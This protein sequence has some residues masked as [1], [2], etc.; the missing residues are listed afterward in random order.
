MINFKSFGFLELIC[1]GG[2]AATASPCSFGVSSF[3]TTLMQSSEEI[4]VGSS[5][6]PRF[7]K[8]KKVIIVHG[9]PSKEEYAI[10][11]PPNKS[12]WIPWLKENLEKEKIKVE[13]PLMPECWNPIYDN[14]KKEFEKIG[15]DENSILVGHSAGGGFLVRWL[16]E[17]GK[18]IKK[19][20]LVAPAISN[21]KED[22]WEN[23][24][25]YNFKI[26]K[27]ILKNVGEILIYVSDDDDNSILESVK[28]FSK[29]LGVVPKQFHGY[30]HF[31][32]GD[33]G[34]EKFPELLEEILK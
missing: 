25:L 4:F 26:N 27:E 14:W 8:M 17:T 23:Q 34:T 11:N 1:A 13:I 3:S 15:V 9:S 32:K 31:C 6:T 30:G 33:M 2:T 19:L 10:A 7:L 28:V 12:H 21:K 29:E 5:P 16:G 18:K 22:D 20:I 24:E